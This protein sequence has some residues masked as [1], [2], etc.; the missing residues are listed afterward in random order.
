MMN[1]QASQNFS[2]ARWWSACAKRERMI[3]DWE[4]EREREADQRVAESETE[5]ASEGLKDLQGGEEGEV[6]EIDLG[7]A[8]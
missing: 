5:S 2:E 8:K 1:A 7:E 6:V 3:A 4:R